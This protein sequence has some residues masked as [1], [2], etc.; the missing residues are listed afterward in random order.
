MRVKRSPGSRPSGRAPHLGS[1]PRSRP[2]GRPSQPR[3]SASGSRRH[4]P[5]ALSV[6]SLPWVSD[7]SVGTI[8]V[9]RVPPVPPPARRTGHLRPGTWDRTRLP[10][11]DRTRLPA[12]DRT[13]L[14]ARD[15][16]RFPAE[17]LTLFPA[18]GR[19]PFRPGHA[20]GTGDLAYGRGHQGGHGDGRVPVPQRDRVRGPEPGVALLALRAGQPAERI[21]PPPG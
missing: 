12:R 3:A 8:S 18:G 21:D 13:R 2:P 11:R 15:R 9:G 20:I 5:G 14:P 17:G 4:R 16:T 19:T 7:P 1:G 10:A 6:P